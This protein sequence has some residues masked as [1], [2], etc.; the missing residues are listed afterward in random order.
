MSTRLVMS[1]EFSPWVK[2]SVSL[3]SFIRSQFWPEG[4]AAVGIWPGSAG[5]AQESGSGAQLLAYIDRANWPVALMAPPLKSWK[6]IPAG[7]VL[8]VP[9]APVGFPGCVASP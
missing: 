6:K 4:L 5:L 9:D 8:V 1:I 7:K 3:G 2:R